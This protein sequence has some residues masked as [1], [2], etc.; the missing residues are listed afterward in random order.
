[1]RNVDIVESF[2]PEKMISNT[3][4]ISAFILQGVV[5]TTAVRN[6]KELFVPENN[7]EAAKAEA[8]ALPSM[9]INKVL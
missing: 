3:S 5:P 7:Y 4:V 8:E 2:F 9:E 6:V 1:M